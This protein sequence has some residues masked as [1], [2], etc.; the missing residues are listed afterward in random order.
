MTQQDDFELCLD[1]SGPVSIRFDAVGAI[2]YS[3]EL[4]R[5]FTSDHYRR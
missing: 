1:T 3:K 4:M 5:V 2:E